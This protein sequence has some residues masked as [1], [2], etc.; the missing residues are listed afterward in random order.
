VT[1]RS[2]SGALELG[3]L[4][5][6]GVGH[7]A[8]DPVPVPRTHELE[9]GTSAYGFLAGRSYQGKPRRVHADERTVGADG[10]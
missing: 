6:E 2:L 8:A 1:G 5:G 4:A 9:V 3:G 10:V 7:Q